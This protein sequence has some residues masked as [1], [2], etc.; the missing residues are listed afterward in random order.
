[1]GYRPLRAACRFGNPS[2][3]YAHADGQIWPAQ[4]PAGFSQR[5]G[6]H[7]IC[8]PRLLGYG[9]R[10]SGCNYCYLPRCGAVEKAESLQQERSCC[11]RDC[12]ELA[13]VGLVKVVINNCVPSRNGLC[14]LSSRRLEKGSILML[15][16]V[17]QSVALALDWFWG[18]YDGTSTRLAT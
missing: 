14:I 13:L 8:Q 4:F 6:K 18:L 2:F 16:F 5:I 7:S 15:V 11:S 17:T 12:Y 10:A 9:H 1:M 3:R